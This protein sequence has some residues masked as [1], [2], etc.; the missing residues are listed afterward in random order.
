MGRDEGGWHHR[1]DA[2][3]IL[4]NDGITPSAAKLAKSNN[5][6]RCISCRRTRRS[7]WEPTASVA[8][9][10]YHQDTKYWRELRI[11]L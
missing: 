2:F 4:G 7:V 1:I 9:Q 3:L 11:L 10:T 8:R 6:P 5:K